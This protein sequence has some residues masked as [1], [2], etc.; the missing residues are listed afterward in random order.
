[1]PEQPSSPPDDVAASNDAR[2]RRVRAFGWILAIVTFV[3]TLWYAARYV[4]ADADN[5]PQFGADDLPAICGL[6]VSL[7]L[8][9]VANGLVLRDLL[10]K[11]DAHLRMGAW[12]GLTLVASMLNLVSPMKGGAA[13]RA[14]YLKKV[15]GVSYGA[16]AGILGIAFVGG[17][18]ASGGLAAVSLL[19][20]GM[21]GGRAGQVMLAASVLL[22]ASLWIVLRL[23][24]AVRHYAT[25][26]WA[27]LV[28]FA[29][30]W[31]AV[32]SDR[33]LAMRI[34]AWCFFGALFHGFAFVLAFRLSGFEGHWLVPMASS[35]FARIGALVALTPAGLGIYEAFGAVSARL[36]GADPGPA[37]VA[38]LLVRLVSSLIT[39]AGG[40]AFLPVIGAHAAHGASPRRAGDDRSTEDSS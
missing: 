34:A 38:V 32:S 9:M 40:A 7:A 39:I 23:E 2:G 16:F 18:A 4:R 26:R 13:L 21:P 3:P 14:V 24:P 22:A 31:R 25:R 33:A 30:T 10:A 17:I 8:V 11:L 5:L 1:M 12:L 20:L 35:A 29:N 28:R 19:C 6:V 37:V 27:G 36:V 15:H